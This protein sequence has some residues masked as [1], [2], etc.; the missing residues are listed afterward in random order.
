MRA[1][2]TCQ[3]R[4]TKDVAC[5][6][7]RPEQKATGRCRSRTWRG[8]KKRNLRPGAG[9]S[10]L[11]RLPKALPETPCFSTKASGSGAQVPPNCTRSFDIAGR[12]VAG[13]VHNRSCL[14]PLR[15]MMLHSTPTPEVP[16][17][18]LNRRHDANAASLSRSLVLGQ[19]RA[20]CR[21]PCTQHQSAICN[22]LVD[23][24]VRSADC[25]NRL[26]A[27]GQL[28]S[29]QAGIVPGYRSCGKGGD[30]SSAA[31]VDGRHAHRCRLRAGRSGWAVGRAPGVG[32]HRR[33]ALIVCVAMPEAALPVR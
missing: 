5:E 9:E 1:T 25:R 20:A 32:S 18:T 12:R 6:A 24:S 33:T 16:Y 2:T 19:S 30:I 11:L 14:V 13:I 28:V 15:G 29:K 31:A 26:G 4:R 22:R 17:G 8:T 27:D 7:C 10:V 21:E 23:R 3:A